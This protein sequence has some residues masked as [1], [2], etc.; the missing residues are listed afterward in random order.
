MHDSHPVTLTGA[1]VVFRSSDIFIWHSGL[2]FGGSWAQVALVV[3]SA[4]N[5]ALGQRPPRDLMESIRAARI[6]VA[7]TTGVHRADLDYGMATGSTPLML[8][9]IAAFD[10]SPGEYA[11]GIEIPGLDVRYRQPFTVE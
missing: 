2:V 3:E 11:L 10:P 8:C 7:R 4:E 9:R 5:P 6:Y 1:D